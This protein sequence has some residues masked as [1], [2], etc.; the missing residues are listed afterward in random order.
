MSLTG[1][2][3]SCNGVA[4]ALQVWPFKSSELCRCMSQNNVVVFL[5][6]HV[7]LKL[8]LQRLVDT[9]SLSNQ[10]VSHRIPLSTTQYLS[11]KYQELSSHYKTSRTRIKGYFNSINGT[12]LDVLKG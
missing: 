12:V 9:L 2:L 4:M 7:L 10:L 8:G 5:L 11:L 6:L 3:C 1:A